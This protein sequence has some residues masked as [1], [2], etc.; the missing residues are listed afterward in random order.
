M[1]QARN[2]TASFALSNIHYSVIAVLEPSDGG[3]VRFMP[4]Q[5]EGGFL[6]N[7]SVSLLPVARTGYVFSYWAGDLSGS[8][9]P[10]TLVVSEN[11]NITA[12]FNP[13]VTVYCSPSDGGSVE[14]SSSPDG[15]AVGT[16][17]TLNETPAEGYRFVGWEGEDV[18]GSDKSI[19]VTVDAPKAITAR[20][21]EQSASRW[22]VWV[23]IGL[24][25]LCGAL[26]L[27]RVAYAWINHLR[28]HEPPQPED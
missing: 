5:P 3:S 14:P 7:Q 26:I 18:S 24:A 6:V 16:K 15:Y 27:A 17:L 10:S 12:V 20:F 4:D 22:W 13:T 9:N 1:N 21:T 28:S 8:A 25:G 11:T 19:T 2:I 23:V